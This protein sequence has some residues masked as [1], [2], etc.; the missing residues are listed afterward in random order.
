VLRFP[1]EV[2][3]VGGD[4][5]DEMLP[6]FAIGRSEEVLAILLDRPSSPVMKRAKRAKV[7]G[8]SSTGSAEPS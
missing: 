1:K 6:L 7:A 3:L 5:I 4:G 2:G 8:E